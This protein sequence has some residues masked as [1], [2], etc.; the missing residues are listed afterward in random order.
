MVRSPEKNKSSPRLIVKLL[1]DPLKW[2]FRSLANWT[3]RSLVQVPDL[4][5][6]DV[7]SHM[8]WSGSLWKFSLILCEIGCA[9]FYFSMPIWNLRKQKLGKWLGPWLPSSLLQLL[10][11]TVTPSLIASSRGAS[12]PGIPRPLHNELSIP[13]LGIQL[14]GG[15]QD[16]QK[17]YQETKMKPHLHFNFPVSQC[18]ALCHGL[19]STRFLLQ[20][21]TRRHRSAAPPRSHLVNP[22]ERKKEWTNEPRFSHPRDSYE[23]LSLKIGL[24]SG[25]SQKE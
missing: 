21:S 12:D 24:I 14:W 18:Q 19:A 4:A 10:G 3:R 1:S 7:L 8:Q 9:L 2:L 13:L 20:C 17:H 15:N 11:N 22:V 6:L 25:P 16:F 5:I 23:L